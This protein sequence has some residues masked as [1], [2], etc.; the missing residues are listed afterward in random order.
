MEEMSM[1]FTPGPGE[2]ER[3]KK[4]LME[5]MAICQRERLVFAHQATGIV[6]ATAPTN[7]DAQSKVLAVVKIIAPDVMEWA[8]MVWTDPLNAKP[9]TWEHAKPQ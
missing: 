3:A 5:I 6:V 9:G 4:A 7:L 1:S 8:P 2:A